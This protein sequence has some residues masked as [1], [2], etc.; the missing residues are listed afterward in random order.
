MI[1][2]LPSVLAIGG[3][4]MVPAALTLIGLGGGMDAGNTGLDV[5]VATHDVEQVGG[6]VVVVGGPGAGCT[7]VVAA[8]ACSMGPAVG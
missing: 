2:R 7:G 5:G 3:S 6:P 1:S 8:A 4:S